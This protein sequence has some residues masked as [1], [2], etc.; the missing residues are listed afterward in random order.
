MFSLIGGTMSDP[1]SGPVH[2]VLELFETELASVKF[3]D[4]EADV[5]ARA[6]EQTMVAA[7]AV[8]QAEATLETARAALADKQE[9]LA[10][11]AQ[12]ALAYARV[13]AED[14]AALSSRIDAIALSRSTRR[15]VK[16]GDEMPGLSDTPAPLRRRGRP[17][18]TQ[19]SG[20]LAISGGGAPP[21]E[22][23]AADA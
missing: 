1:I 7:Q 13:Y 10:Q 16:L 21:M 11:K 23:I 19:E 5:L 18:A 4:L 6:A 22:P 15:T 2:Q 3:A 14:D 9:V 8:A 17:R 20:L 12:R